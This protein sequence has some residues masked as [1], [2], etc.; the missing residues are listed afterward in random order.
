MEISAAGS[1]RKMKSK[2][3]GM[4][5]S[6]KTSSRILWV[7]E[8]VGIGTHSWFMRTSTGSTGDAKLV[9]CGKMARIVCSLRGGV[10]MKVPGSG[11]K[12]NRILG[13]SVGV[14]NPTVSH[15]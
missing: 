3:H 15:V 10:C 12:Q 6:V 1:A 2:I 14:R 4:R 5:H 13:F 8:A 11:M 9:A 7:S